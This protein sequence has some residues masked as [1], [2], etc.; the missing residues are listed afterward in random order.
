MK[1]EQE[2]EAISL[3]S[4]HPSAVP[5][6]LLAVVLCVIWFAAL[7]SNLGNNP[8]MLWLS[9]IVVISLGVIATWSLFKAKSQNDRAGEMEG[10]RDLIFALSLDILCVMS[11]DGHLERTNPAFLNILGLKPDELIGSALIDLVHQED[12][13][14]ARSGLRKL[15]LGQSANFEV[16]C[17]CGDGSHRWLHWSANPQ[18][19]EH[20]I[21]AVAHDVTDRKAAEDALRSEF[22]FRKAMED[23]V[24]T[25]LGAIDMAGR[26]IYINRAFSELTGLPSAELIGQSPPFS[27]WDERDMRANWEVLRQSLAGD[28]PADGADMRIRRDDGKRLDIRL[29]VSPL[30]NAHGNQTGWMTAMTDITESR[31]ASAQLE[32]A[33]E[34]FIAVLDGLDAYVG[35]LDAVSGDL[36]YAN[37]A[38]AAQGKPE[39]SDEAIALP[40]PSPDEYLALPGNLTNRDLPFELFDGELQDKSG[41]WFH[42]RERALRWVDGRIVRLAVATDIST[43]KHA[44]QLAHEQEARLQ[45]TS[46]L[47]TMGEMAS[48]LAHEL[49]QPLSAIS[50]YCMGSVNRLRQGNCPQEDILSAMEKASTQAARAG[51]IVRR[52]RDFVRKSEPQRS[53]VAIPTI[54]EEALGIAGIEAK[55]LGSKI[56]TQIPDGLPMVMADRIMI[57]QVLMN[58]VKNAAEAMQKVPMEQR[59]IN[60]AAR[61][62]EGYIEVAVTDNG[63]GIAPAQLGNLFSP[64]FTT[65]PEGM[66]MGLNI[67]RSIIEYHNGRLWVDP[68]PSGGSIFR[69]MLPQ[70]KILDHASF[71]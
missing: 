57:E 20:R 11:L 71:D 69:F 34:R 38:L 51:D 54:I 41:R 31:R 27:F 15:A 47:I 62:V 17:R 53:L 63:C 36:L 39:D 56:N 26:I 45:S 59:H 14:L 24:L 48:T 55:R 2:P 10:E 61:L 50:N 12:H 66:G 65:K 70:E 7:P 35:V 58:L 44:E 60:V 37:R 52:V 6:L 19:G 5:V 18:L 67:C 22:A 13:R 4:R 32:A 16:R 42:L 8:D 3:F 29:H 49:N 40:Q 46:R 43:I 9:A 23:S 1:P 25:G 33:Q 64:F 68:N 21:Y 30:I 28:A